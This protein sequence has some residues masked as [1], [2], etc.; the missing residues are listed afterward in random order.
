MDQDTAGHIIIKD[1]AFMTAGINVKQT[2]PRAET[3]AGNKTKQIKKEL[4]T[5]KPHGI[6]ADA[7]C[8]VDGA[9]PEM[10]TKM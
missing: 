10:G 3:G 1:A 4:K 2:V 5:Q 9:K 7:R 6:V 8:F